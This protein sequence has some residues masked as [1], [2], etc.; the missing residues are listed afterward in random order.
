MI[1]Y[2][3]VLHYEHICVQYIFSLYRIDKLPSEILH[4]SILQ[5]YI[6]SVCSVVSSISSASS[7]EFCDPQMVCNTNYYI[8]TF[9][10]VIVLEQKEVF[11]NPYYGTCTQTLY[12]RC[13]CSDSTLTIYLGDDCSTIP[14][15]RGRVWYDSDFICLSLNGTNSQIR[16]LCCN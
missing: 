3:L 6:S 15:I 2:I 9:Q 4:P 1:R 14:S 5:C 11:M 16:S 13:N 12:Q 7:G 10:E 8:Q